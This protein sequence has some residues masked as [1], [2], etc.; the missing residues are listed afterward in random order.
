MVE[1][2]KDYYICPSC[3]TE[4]GND[5][6]LFTYQELRSQWLANDARW[7]SRATPPPIG[8]NAYEQLMLAG[9][10]QYEPTAEDEVGIVDFGE[11]TV[12]VNNQ[13]ARIVIQGH[14]YGIGRSI[15]NAIGG[16]RLVL[17]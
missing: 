11:R 4:F 13:L 7:F 9:F 2:P 17:A 3:G 14:V 12:A 8:W 1:P 5:D 16:G 10:L 15:S 6:T